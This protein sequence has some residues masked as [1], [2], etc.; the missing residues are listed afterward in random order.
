M[1]NI[2]LEQSYEQYIRIEKSKADHAC[3]PDV[4]RQIYEL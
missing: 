1:N 4:D 2:H 3:G